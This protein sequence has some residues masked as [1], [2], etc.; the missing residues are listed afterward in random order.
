MD[1][2]HRLT[3]KEIQAPSLNLVQLRCKGSFKIEDNHM[4]FH[5]YTRY[6]SNN[7]SW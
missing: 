1:K 7:C 3:K 4:K 6:N 5:K 2:R